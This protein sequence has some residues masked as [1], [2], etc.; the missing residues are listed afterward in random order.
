MNP[1]RFEPRETLTQRLPEKNMS[2]K[3]YVS[4]TS[5]AL[6]IRHWLGKQIGKLSNTPMPK[7][8]SGK[9]SLRKL[10]AIATEFKVS[11]PLLVTD[12][13]LVRI[14]LVQKVKDALDLSG[15]PYAV[16]DKV[17]PNPHHLLVE[18]G[19]K[20]YKSNRYVTLRCDQLATNKHTHTHTHTHTCTTDVTV[21]LQ[22]VVVV[23]WIVRK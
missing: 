10:G 23:R 15:I 4:E 7:V 17:V 14:G 22:L 11:K 16:Y 5:M 6:P 19:Y 8:Y 20:L 21:L 13:D 9:G 18:E 1:Q 3:T 12:K 2:D